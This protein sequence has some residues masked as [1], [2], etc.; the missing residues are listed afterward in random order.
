MNKFGTPIDDQN[1]RRP[2]AALAERQTTSSTPGAVLAGICHARPDEV[3]ERSAYDATLGLHFDSLGYAS[4]GAA[5]SCVCVGCRERG[6]VRRRRPA[7]RSSSSTGVVTRVKRSS[8]RKRVASL[9][10]A[11]SIAGRLRTARGRRPGRRLGRA[12]LRRR[13]RQLPDVGE[14]ASCARSSARTSSTGRTAACSS[15]RSATSR[16]RPE[17]HACRSSPRSLVPYVT[18]FEPN[19][20]TPPPGLSLTISGVADARLRRHDRD[21]VAHRRRRR[22]RR[23]VT[24]RRRRS[25]RA[26]RRSRSTCSR[27]RSRGPPAPSCADGFADRRRDRRARLRA[28]A[29][30]S[31]TSSTVRDARSSW[32]HEPLLFGDAGGTGDESIVSPGKLVFAGTAGGGGLS[33]ISVDAEEIVAAAGRDRLDAVDRRRRPAHGR[34]DRRLRRRQRSRPSGSSSARRPRSSRT[35]TPGFTGGDVEL[36]ASS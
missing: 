4:R 24:I 10:G 29:T 30:A 5:G 26:R 33:D 2:P 3:R 31:T 21:L 6:R 28:S 11:F 22:L 34:L 32:S 25:R 1:T 13:L 18:P 36:T 16:P 19:P 15:R 17:R 20:F 7:A 8:I 12:D 27:T 14:R 35:P 23:L 9:A